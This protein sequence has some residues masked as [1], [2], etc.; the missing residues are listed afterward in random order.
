MAFPF[1]FDAPDL[2]VLHD[3]LVDSF[4]CYP[5]YCAFAVKQ[6]DQ[7]VEFDFCI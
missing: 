3:F 1:D 4:S 5:K 6:M 2:Y 7:Y